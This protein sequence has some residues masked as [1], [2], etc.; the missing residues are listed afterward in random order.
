MAQVTITINGRSYPVAC[1]DGEEQR[2]EELGRYIDAKIKTFARELG[3]IGESRLLVLAALVLADE[4]ADAR[5][6]SGES[7]SGNGAGPGEDA[8]AGIENL[9]QRIESIATR[10][11]TLHI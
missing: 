10:L 1:N 9:A 11:E 5:A 7:R 4:L 2:I 6:A 8:A 3:Q